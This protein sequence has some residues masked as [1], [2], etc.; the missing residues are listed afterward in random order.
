MSSPPPSGPEWAGA[1]RN[2]EPWSASAR[3]RLPRARVAAPLSDPLVPPDLR[4]WIERVIAVVRRSLV[5]LLIIQLGVAA[6]SALVSF[7]LGPTLAAPEDPNSFDSTLVLLGVMIAIAVSVFA[8]GA[9]VY[10]AIQDAAGR[11]A[12]AGEALR[13]ATM[14]A[15]ALIG[16]G[17]AAG[18]LT[19]F[20]FLMLIVPGLYLAIVFGAALAGVVTVERAGIARC[21]ELV[22]ARFWPTLGRMALAVAGGGA[23]TI[24]AGFVVSALSSPGSFNEAVLRAVVDVPLGMV[25]VGVAVVT[26]AE[27]RFHERGE[28]FTATLA[29]ELAR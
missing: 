12:T 11:E 28:V 29:A 15:P 14:R 8:Q 24:V 27:L 23:Y 9:S 20:G 21:F 18:L 19:L 25:F 3:Q 7:T 10:V 1:D 2:P 17:L 6:V 4:G 13:F 22:N 16:W 26:Y 5:P